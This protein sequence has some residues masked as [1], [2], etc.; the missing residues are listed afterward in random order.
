MPLAVLW[1]RYTVAASS[2][3]QIVNLI[4]PNC[5]SVGVTAGCMPLRISASV[6]ADLGCC[7]SIVLTDGPDLLGNSAA[8]SFLVINGSDA[9]ATSVSFFADFF[10]G[11]EA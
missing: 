5:G 2:Q 1:L 3:P 6:G 8:A 9:R 11:R 4:A 10:F 7:A